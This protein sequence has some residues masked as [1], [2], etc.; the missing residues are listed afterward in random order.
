M[1]ETHA[2]ARFENGSSSLRLLATGEA[3]HSS[4]GAWEEAQSLYV[5][6]SGLAEKLLLAE[7]EPLVLYDLG[8][9]IAANAIAAIEVARRI[10]G[11]ELQIVS[12]ESDLSG[13]ALAL[14]SREHFPWLQENEELAQ[15]LLS[16]GNVRDGR[17]H[18]ELRSGDFLMARE[19]PVPELIFFDFYSP[20]TD[21][22]LWGI[23]SFQKLFAACAPRRARNLDSTLVTYCSATSARSAM[24]LA[25]FFVGH[26]PSTG[27]KR[28]TT[29]A[30][31][32]L[33]SL[34]APLGRDWFEHLRRSA[35]PWPED[36]EF[37][38]RMP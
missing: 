26:G 18:W 14:E 13:L 30:S 36:F 7:R 24:L 31:T 34:S 3:M 37:S 25:G 28:D 38:Q 4:I 1:T 33:A 20:K 15:T 22:T 23:H 10:G 5:R 21:S 6:G 32:I 29:I 12:F 16:R 17:I 19:L 9:G 2:L 35:K 8:L 11:R 27:A